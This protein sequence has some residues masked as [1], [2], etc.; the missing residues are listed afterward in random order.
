MRFAAKDL[1][2]I[3]EQG[4]TRHALDRAL[5]L[6]AAACPELPAD[7]LADRPLGQRNQALLRLRQHSFGPRIVAHADCPDC[8]DR[9]EL[10][11]RTDAFLSEAAA[12]DTAAEF[13]ADGL[14][15]RAVTSRDLAAVLGHA[16]AESAALHLLERCC[17]SRPDTAT[18]RDLLGTVEAGLESLDPDADIEL[19]LACET[20][21]H[22]WNAPFDIGAMLWDEVDA[23]ARALLGEVHALAGAY[24]WCERDILALSEQ[25]R[26]AYLGMVAA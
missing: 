23:R 1:L 3:W 18:L 8:G 21:G 24:G 6:F 5:L 17:V 13:E 14:R 12:P 26:A 9:M 11:L 20:C 22:A 2:A 16:D 25:R 19:S 15:F 4:Q 7:Q 10:A